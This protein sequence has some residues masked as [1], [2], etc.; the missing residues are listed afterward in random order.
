MFAVCLEFVSCASQAV[1]WPATT[2][3]RTCLGV[4][5][6]VVPGQTTQAVDTDIHFEWKLFICGVFIVCWYHVMNIVNTHEV[7]V[8]TLQWKVS[9]QVPPGLHLI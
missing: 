3:S 9:S 1:V 4:R 2:V 8:K 6:R 5:G 7:H